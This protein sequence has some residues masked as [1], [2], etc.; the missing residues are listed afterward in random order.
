M[1]KL[2]PS[3]KAA[4]LIGVRPQTLRAWIADRRVEYTRVGSRNYFNPEQ[5]QKIAVV[6]PVRE[7]EEQAEVRH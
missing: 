1:K 4:E 5:I 2:I 7:S 6:V 3:P